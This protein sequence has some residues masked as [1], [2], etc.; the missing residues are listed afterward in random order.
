M[1][2]FLFKTRQRS[3][4]TCEISHFLNAKSGF[5]SHFYGGIMKIQKGTY[6][7]GKL[8]NKTETPVTRT[9]SRHKN[10]PFHKY[11]SSPFHSVPPD[12]TE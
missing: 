4:L 7:I 8:K 1:E 2:F 9:Q 11:S 10:P 12:S 6:T 5:L 3:H